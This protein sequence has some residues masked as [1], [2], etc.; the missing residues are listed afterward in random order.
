MVACKGYTMTFPDGKS[1]HT[2]YPFA[3]HDT[4][5][6]PWDY[7]LKNGTMKLFTH[8]CHG[9]SGGGTCQPCQ[10]LKKNKALEK[11]LMRMEDGTHENT[12]F[13]Y[14]GFSG[15]QEML[16]R[17]NLLIEFYWLRG[18]NQAKKLLAKAAAL[19]NQK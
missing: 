11:I 8:G 14:H 2:S 7:A 5:V 13:A 6:L 1:P 9:S 4:M 16:H 12:G 10:Q 17:K 15:L 3:L 18:L 19:S